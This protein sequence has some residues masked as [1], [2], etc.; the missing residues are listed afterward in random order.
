MTTIYDPYEEAELMRD[1]ISKSY[2]ITATSKFLGVSYEE[3]DKRA[4]NHEVLRFRDA[5]GN[6]WFPRFQFDSAG[7]VVPYVQSV[8]RILLDRGFTEL[9]A[10]VWLTR[11]SGMFGGVSAVEF[12]RVDPKRFGIVLHLARRGNP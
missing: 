7:G 4:Q 9:E 1:V 8:V 3:L 5:G 12:M 6:A 10:A 2:D 11:G